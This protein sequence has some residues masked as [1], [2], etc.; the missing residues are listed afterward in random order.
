MSQNKELFSTTAV[1]TSYST[2]LPIA[3]VVE[4]FMS[5]TNLGLYL[6]PIA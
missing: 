5:T 6:E 2:N 1:K 4:N 3:S